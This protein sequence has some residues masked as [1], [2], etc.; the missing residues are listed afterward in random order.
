MKYLA[1]VA[2]VTFILLGGLILFTNVFQMDQLPYQFKLIMGVVLVLYG[3]FRLL[4]T[5]FRKPPKN[6]ED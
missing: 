6:E 4:A 2:G 1:Y 5:V 3:A